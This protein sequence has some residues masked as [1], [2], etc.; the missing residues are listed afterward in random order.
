MIWEFG[1][2]PLPD[3]VLSAANRLV[4]AVPLDIAAL[5]A[6]DEVDAIRARAAWMVKE[7]RFPTDPTGRR[8]PWP[9]V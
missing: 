3:H 1:D 5:L 4:D 9:L 2:E 6:D 8:Y 7:R